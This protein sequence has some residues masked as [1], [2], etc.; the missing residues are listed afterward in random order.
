MELWRALFEYPESCSARVSLVV[1]NSMFRDDTRNIKQTCGHRQDQDVFGWGTCPWKLYLCFLTRVPFTQCN[2]IAVYGL[3]HP[4]LLFHPL[5]RTKTLASLLTCQ[6]YWNAATVH[7]SCRT[8]GWGYTLPRRTGVYFMSEEDCWQQF[9]V[10]L[11]KFLVFWRRASHNVARN[12][13]NWGRSAQA[14]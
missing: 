14:N 3:K 13:I 11:A 1:W 8:T 2:Q 4:T 5:L 7:I 6:W 10:Q 9:A 12:H